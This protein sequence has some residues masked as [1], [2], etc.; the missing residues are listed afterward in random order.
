[1]KTRK[2]FLFRVWNTYT[3]WK[4][5]DQEKMNIKKYL[6]DKKHVFSII[7]DDFIDNY[8]QIVEFKF[9]FKP[10]KTFREYENNL[11][12]PT[13]KRQLKLFLKYK[14]QNMGG[15]RKSI[16]KNKREFIYN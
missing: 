7:K 12:D 10:S 1:M 8:F 6:W 3:N 14:K 5:L 9:F 13:Y 15:Y 2:N 4:R 16:G 11:K